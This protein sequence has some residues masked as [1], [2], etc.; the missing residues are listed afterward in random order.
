MMV[1]VEQPCS[2]ADQDRC[3][4]AGQLNLLNIS[5]EG[6]FKLKLAL[7]ARSSKDWPTNL[8]PGPLPPQ[9]TP[10]CN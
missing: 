1:F 5:I 2:F 7:E 3:I 4:E 8:L 6:I 10:S 9:G